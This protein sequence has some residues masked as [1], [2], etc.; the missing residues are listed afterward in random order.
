MTGATQAQSL[1]WELFIKKRASATRGIPPG[2]E[3]LA[4]VA[5][6]VTLLWGDHDAV[7]VDTFLSDAHNGELA[8]WIDSK[9]RTLRA[10]YLTH[11]HPDHFFGLTRLLNRFPKARAIAM[12]NVVA[13]MRITSSA[14]VVESNWKRRFPGQV[15]LHLTVAQ[16]LDAESFELEGHELRV[17]PMGHTDTDDTTA[18]HIPSLD[19][20][21]SG[22]V[23]YNETHAFLVETDRCGRQAWLRALDLVTTI[24][25]STVIVGH[26]PL[27]PDN[28]PD[29]IDATRRYI[30]DF[31]RLERETGTARGCYGPP[32][33]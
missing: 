7:L 2:K 22:D 14:E 21:M 33:S 5:N 17:I 28:S 20:L 27:N 10:I 8:D 31:D 15:P 4:W 3:T 18:L 25:P 9:G 23:V 1:Q 16:A 11:A 12:P 19:L 32:C 26:G 6:T 29:H 13:A 24:N 30:L